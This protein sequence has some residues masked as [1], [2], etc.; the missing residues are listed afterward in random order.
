MACGLLVLI[1]LSA[2]TIL[3]A[4]LL[5]SPPAHDLRL[6][7]AFLPASG[8][9]S[10]ALSLSFPRLYSRGVLRGLRGKL[11][12]AIAL[13]SALVLIN[14]GFTAYLM[15]L[16]S[17][18]LLLLFVLFTFSVGMSC[19]FAYAMAA[20]FHARI[21]RLLAGVEA[22]GEGKL[23][24]R[25][26]AEEDDELG[27][28][29]VA[30]NK[31]AGELGAAYKSRDDLEA[32]RHHLIGAVSHDLRTPLA[33]IRA[34]VESINDGVVDDPDTIERYHQGM[35]AEVAYLTRLIDDLFELSQIDSG[36]L[37][38]HREPG[39]LADL[40]SGTLEVL[41]PHA[42]QRGVVLRGEVDEA[43]P[44]VTMDTLRMQ[45]VL[46]NLV[47]NAVRHTPTDGTVVI[48][49]TDVGRDVEVSVIDSGDGIDAQELTRIFER[50]NRGANKARSRD[51][52]GSGLGLSI[53]K[54]IVEL[55]GGRIWARNY[56]GQG[57]QF[58]FA[59]PKTS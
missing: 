38:L 1:G 18:D 41:I 50:F 6:M 39:S 13:S 58:T 30:F 20:T 19:F 29:A 23:A 26:E 21:R 54:G 59:L 3:L 47:Q 57:A 45:R 49:A 53:A 7:A 2:L 4:H 42:H 32:A 9:V 17:H 31:M 40:V 35:Q 27:E 16:S 46:Y 51:D 8:A 33:T 37:E 22:I 12:A 24:T 36:L 15:F 14:V 5:L 52:G 43:I 11:F 34:M 28:L 55:H 48:R 10:V 56:Q 25:I 44:L